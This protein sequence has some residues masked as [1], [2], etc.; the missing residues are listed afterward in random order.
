MS[1]FVYKNNLKKFNFCIVL[2][3]TF[4]IS[5]NIKNEIFRRDIIWKISK[6]DLITF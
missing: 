6:T 4:V 5:N 3:F 2:F 1:R